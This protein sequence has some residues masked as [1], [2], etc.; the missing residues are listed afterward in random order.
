MVSA[1]ASTERVVVNGLEF[2][3]A[4]DRHVLD[5]VLV[6]RLAELAEQVEPGRRNF[7]FLVAPPGTGKSTLVAL[8]LAR[9]AHLD[10]DA[11][12]I[13]GFHHSQ[14]YLDTHQVETP[15]GPAPLARIKGAPETFDMHALAGHLEMART[16]DLAW[17]VYDRTIHDVVPAAQH[18]RA[19]LV[20]VEGNWLLLDE[21]GWSEL[22]AYSS[23][24]IFIDADAELLRER[25]VGR[26][27]RGGL[28]LRAAE[29]FYERSDRVNVERVLT[30]TDRSAIDLLL[31]LQ[32]DGTIQQGGSQ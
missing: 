23:F 25:L 11:V 14:R 9:A 26:K 16:R 7:V 18:V 20:V 8:L 31:H 24:N 29:E 1:P 28:S 3:A 32:T 2:D 10:V 6:P 17:P 4:V 27:V 12:G 21:P 5:S 13:D 22:T 30:H 15:G 19:G